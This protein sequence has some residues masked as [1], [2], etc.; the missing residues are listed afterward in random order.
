VAIGKYIY[1]M[2]H[3]QNIPHILQ[4]GLCCRTHENADPNFINIGHKQLIIDRDQHQIDVEGVGVLG[5]YIPFY[6]A[7][8]SPMLYLIMNGLQGVQKRP[9][10]DLIFIVCKLEEVSQSG[11]DFLFTDRNAKMRLA[12]PFTDIRDL[13][14]LNWDCINTRDWKN[15]EDNY[16]KRD[17]KQAEFLVRHHLPVNLI[18]AI[19]VKNEEKKTYIEE[20][21][22]IFGMNIPVHIDTEHKLYYP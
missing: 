2:V 4:Y 19:V 13:D 14:K 20:Q 18:S 8:H 21:L 1:R 11:V 10:K 15:T 6:L 12:K 22:H 9:Q 16:Q 3:W 5:E 17:L 7:G